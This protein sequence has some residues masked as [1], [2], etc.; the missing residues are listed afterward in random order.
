MDELTEKI[1]YLMDKNQG[2]IIEFVKHMYKYDPDAVE[3]MLDYTKMEEGHLT[4]RRKYDECIDK[5]KWA[6]GN[7]RGA[8]WNFE[9]IKKNSK[10]DF[11]HVDFTE[12]DYAYLVNMLYA[13]CCKEFTDPSFYLKLAKCLLE[14][15]DEE[16]KIYHGHYAKNKTSKHGTQ[17]YYNSYDEEDRRRRRMYADYDEHD[18][19]DEESR[20]RRYRNDGDYNRTYNDDRFDRSNP[21]SERGFFR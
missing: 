11:S 13:K 20:R 14:D 7:G 3:K 5:L 17:A 9:D 10:I 1:E 12:Y 15:K 4:N 6:N 18:E 19:H 16:T 21:S 8:K 2:K